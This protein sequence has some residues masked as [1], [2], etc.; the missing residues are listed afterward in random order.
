MRRRS[1]RKLYKVI[2][3]LCLFALLMRTAVV[4][5]GDGEG[6]DVFD[7]EVTVVDPVSQD[8]GFSPILYDNTSGLPTSEAN[9]IA[10][11]GD[12]FIWIGSYSG[13]VRYDGNSFERMDST[14]GINSVK[15]LFV[16]SRDRLWI[17]TNESGAA[18]MEEG[19]FRR[20]DEIDGL[21]GSSVRAITEDSRGVIYIA[22]T[23]GITMIDEN[24]R[25]FPMRAPAIVGAFVTMLRAAEDGLLYGTT[26]AGD[27]F[28]IRDGD[29][30]TFLP[31]SE[32]SADGVNCL[33]PDPKNPGYV[34]LETMD[35]VL[36]YGLLEEN[37]F[38][39]EKT[40]DISPLSQV[41]SFE[42]VYGKLWI[43]TRNG[44]GVLDEDGFHYLDKLPLNNSVG[45]VISDY[46]GNL[47]FTS[48]RQGVMKITPNRF[49]DIFERYGL[50]ETVV[51]STCLYNGDL[52]VATD[53]GL[54]VLCKEGAVPSVPID[55]AVTASGEVLPETDLIEM[56]D[57]C[58]IRSIIR[59][60]RNRLWISTWRKFGLLRFDGKEIMAF[61]AADG[62]LSDH[63]RTVCE[64][65]DGSFAAAVTGGVN[66]IEGDSVTAGYNEKNGIINTEILTV[67]E[68]KNGEILCGSDGGGIYILKGSVTLHIGTEGGLTSGA[69]M[70]IKKDP[71]K[72]LYWIVTGNSL[73]YMNDNYEITT[74][75][76]FPYSN[77]FDLYENSGGEV[78]IL[79]SNG[80]Y[81]VRADDLE[82]NKDIDPLHYAI[83]D[84]LPCIATANSYSELTEEGE[85]YVAGTTG[86]AKVNIEAPY[87]TVANL[88][89][90]VP[91]V[92]A[93][94]VRLYPDKEGGFRIGSGVRKL[95]IYG[96]VY[97]YSLINPMVSYQ[98]TGF[99][100]A[101]VTVRRSE[102]APVDY[103]NLRGGT[104][105][106]V[107]KIREPVSHKDKTLSVSIVKEKAF[108][109]YLWFYVLAGLIVVSS[110]A[111]C[112]NKYVEKQMKQLE[113][114]HREEAEKE[115]IASEL[116]MANRIQVG[117]LPGTFPAFPDRTEFDI[118]AS[119]D[120]A[121]EVGGDFYDFFLIDGDHL[122]MVI[123]DVSG[124]GIPA[125]LFMMNAKNIVQNCAMFSRS[126]S[127][128]LTKTNETICANNQMEMFVTVWVGILEISTGIL[129]AANAGHEYP[130]IR[131]AGGAFELYK[132]KHGFVVG[133]ME[134]IVYREYSLPLSPG[135]KL[136]LYTDG[137]PE[138]VNSAREMFGT[139]RMLLALNE[140]PDAPPET[141]LKNVRR[142]V[143]RFTQDTEQ[144]DDLTMLCVEYKG[145]AQI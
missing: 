85:L 39:E 36:S 93:D 96:V 80:I 19:R 81:I 10:E 11:T 113:K 48:T 88:K 133:G 118:Y 61:T 141:V 51:N 79:S 109:E 97:N 59:D 16:D 34:Y 138:A 131:R 140:D 119:M 121:R 127:E 70:R 92:D 108:Y 17:G 135:D 20:W 114:K 87:D 8:S 50:S 129:T 53:D 83:S 72:D 124:K 47:W 82:A 37:G 33:F 111:F 65:E 73:A 94:G 49:T 38:R 57:G 43:C 130:A 23:S 56:L 66:I 98:L 84:G 126:P 102:L 123:A 120:P 71:Y 110:I 26:N 95:T 55:K 101:P 64:R 2:G 46:E 68:G 139:E 5:R 24:M 44:I 21:T 3:A 122:C 137:V 12:G 32:F 91:Y 90:A 31:H 75:D 7:E 69:V 45:R 115:R 100:T 29:L 103:T 76:T 77:N 89:A 18:L 117:I 112:V 106:F 145:A 142:S 107:L 143:D 86:V 104:Y 1:S 52:Y 132:D 78:W 14:T 54:T 9:D 67:E 13:L 105:E 27:V 136:F 28:T 125:A 58:R 35:N 22:T 4:C 25:L 6:D 144:F 63:V 74:I 30:E 41:S 134:G 128:M 40:I 42:S 15:C 60:S 116:T 99:D 62:L